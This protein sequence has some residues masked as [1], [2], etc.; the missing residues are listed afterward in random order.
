MPRRW[1]RCPRP[2]CWRADSNAL[3]L[4]LGAAAPLLESTNAVWVDGLEAAPDD[5][6]GI[7]ANH[8]ARPA[9]PESVSPPQPTAD[10]VFAIDDDV[11]LLPVTGWFG[12]HGSLGG[13]TRSGAYADERQTWLKQLARE[14]LEDWASDYGLGLAFAKPEGVREALVIDT[15]GHRDRAVWLRL[16]TSPRSTWIDVAASRGSVRLTTR[17]ATSGWRW[18]P[19][20]P[21]GGWR[22]QRDRRTGAGSGQ[23]PGRRAYGVAPRNRARPDPARPA[24][25]RRYGAKANADRGHGARRRRLVRSSSSA[26]PTIPPGS[27]GWTGKR[28]RRCWRTASGTG[29]WVPVTDGAALTFEYAPQ[30]WYDIGIAIAAVTA[31][32]IGHLPHHHQCE[33]PLVPGFDPSGRQTSKEPVMQPCHWAGDYRS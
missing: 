3:A 24:A 28:S 20:W 7:L 29:T 17:S 11:A 26:R 9:L 27:L 18:M 30:R 32:R 33:L 21:R 5:A 12:F 14:D 25:H 6:A 2:K 10:A 23:H 16:F 31:G 15:P 4:E 1:R 22:R 13:W 19:G 8:R